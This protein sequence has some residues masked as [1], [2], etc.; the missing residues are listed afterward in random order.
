MTGYGLQRSLC[1]KCGETS[2]NGLELEQ[3]VLKCGAW[4]PSI[5]ITWEHVRN[6]YFKSHS[7]TIESESS[8]V[9]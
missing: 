4:T 1:L 3:M 2:K 7:K 9:D 5:S 8:W 6:A